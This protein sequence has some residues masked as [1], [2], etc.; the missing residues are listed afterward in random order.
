M[1]WPTIKYCAT[2]R[3]DVD[4]CSPQS[5]MVFALDSKRSMENIHV[6]IR[7]VY[8]L[9]FG[10]HHIRGCQFNKTPGQLPVKLDSQKQVPAKITFKSTRVGYLA[11]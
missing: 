6:W 11:T 4:M 8:P 1:N 3:I 5:A 7:F 10:S 9:K 2:Y